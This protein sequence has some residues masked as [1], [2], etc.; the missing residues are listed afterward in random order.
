MSLLR[1]KTR[2]SQ[3]DRN[4]IIRF[5]VRSAFDHIPIYHELLEKQGITPSNVSGQEDLSTLPIVR[6]DDLFGDS[7]STD[8]LHEQVQLERCVEVSTGGYTGLP[9]KIYLTR[10]EMLFRRLQLLT[11]WRR[12]ARLPFALRIVDVGSWVDTNSGFDSARYGPISILRVS[13]ALPLNKQVERISNYAP[14]VVSGYPTTTALLAEAWSRSVTRHSPMLIATRG[15]VLHPWERDTIA[16]GFGGE[17]ADFYNCEEVGNVASECVANP[18]AL[19]VNTDSCV[20]EI[21]NDEDVPLRL[22]S[23][24]RIVL[25]N[26]YSRTMPFI[27]YHAG[28]RGVLLSQ[29]GDR[30]V[31]GSRRPRMAVVEGREDDYVILPDGKRLSPRLVATTVKRNLD[32]EAR[33]IGRTRFFTRMQVVQDGATHLTVRV[34]REGDWPV[35]L[36]ELISSKLCGLHPSLSCAVVA[37]E[38]IPL[39]PSGKFKKVVRR[40]DKPPH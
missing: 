31:C 21:V 33:D 27:R 9:V 4:R 12:L 23:E 32:A 28:D 37:V 15:E 5:L 14:H 39:E 16:G 10:G 17:V 20:L 22:G 35:D 19:H 6:K 18:G 29:S 30:C 11:E 24:G 26:L 7:T 13:N 34:V 25:T 1:F 40:L 36:D 38:S 2:K 3:E 8:R